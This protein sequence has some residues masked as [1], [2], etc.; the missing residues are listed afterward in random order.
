[1]KCRITRTCPE[2]VPID[3]NMTKGAKM[4]STEYDE[5]KAITKLLMLSFLILPL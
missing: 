5:E 4:S 1:M 3:I 2:S